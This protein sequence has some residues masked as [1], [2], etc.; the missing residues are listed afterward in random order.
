MRLVWRLVGGA[1]AFG[2]IFPFSEL[3]GPLLLVVFAD[4]AVVVLILRDLAEVRQRRREAAAAGA[5]LALLRRTVPHL[6]QRR[7]AGVIEMQ[8]RWR[9]RAEA[10]AAR[11]RGEF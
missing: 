9:A 6:R 3:T 10:A 1:L 8:I 7:P 11:R 2:L 4:I 5:Q